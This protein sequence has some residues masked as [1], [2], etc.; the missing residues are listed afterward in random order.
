MPT[1]PLPPTGPEVGLVE[2]WSLR[3][4]T[5]LELPDETT[6]TPSAG[7]SPD[8][9]ALLSTRWGETRLPITDPV[10]LLA[11][12]RLSYGPV[13][14]DN[15][16]AGISAPDGPKSPE[17]DVLAS[18]LRSMENVLV[19]SLATKDGKTLLSVVPI[20]RYAR[21]R[22]AA[23]PAD[24]VLRL[25][26]FAALRTH[27][28]GLCIESPLSG[29]RVVLHQPRSGWLVS[30]F[31]RPFTPQEAAGRLRMPVDT[32]RR[33]VS[34]L[35]A[36]GMVVRGTPPAAGAEETG[37]KEQ[38]AFAEDHDPALLPWSPHD[39]MLH[40][41]S[42]QGRHD[43]PVGATDGFTDMLAAEPVV[44]RAHPGPER[45]PLP[46]PELDRVLDRDPPFTVAL[47]ARRSVRDHGERPLDL[48][49]V[50][51]LLYRSARVRSMGAFRPDD[52][53]PVLTSRPY[54]SIGGA[55]A[56]E[57]YL[58]VSNCAGLARG[59]YHYD[60]VEHA[61]TRVDMAAE[62]LDELLAE[63]RST[64]GLT[65]EPHVLITMTARFRRMT[66]KYSGLAY[67]GLLKDVGVLQQT[68][69][70]VCTAM[71]LGPCALAIG[72]SDLSAHALGL[73]W[74][75]ESAVG[76]FVVSTLPSEP[77]AGGPLTADVE[78]HGH[79]W[80]VRC[81]EEL[82]RALAHTAE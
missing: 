29:Q 52:G 63:A 40:A 34:Y 36:S 48:A 75:T 45:V 2:L 27:E 54:P 1:S 51:E 14:L 8:E 61:L 10:V 25:S 31:A 58:T 76:E 73:D 53:E 33:A 69:Y 28:D 26:R 70:L 21:F 65:A 72:D 44:A 62:S 57:L 3:H 60:P 59:T 4:D 35:E 39:L 46:V 42:R 80:H 74:R 15:V 22:P 16:V 66:L 5:L 67:S 68:L 38:Y 12:E 43:D 13:S 37:T 11:L 32:V 41:R 23:T 49:Q 17:R 20:S 19:R 77:G 79:D 55:Y 82:R 9:A 47:E 50:G 24:A 64:A 30:C 81:A 6:G 18:L 78:V 7:I 71:G 56:L